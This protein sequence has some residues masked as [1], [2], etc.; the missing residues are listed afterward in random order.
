M[1]NNNNAKDGERNH[2]SLPMIK[3]PKLKIGDEFLKIL[4]DNAFNGID[5]GD[6]TN[7]IK[8]VLEITEWIRILDIDKNE[9]R[10]HVFSKSLSGDAKKWWSNEI[11]GTTI[12][13]NE[14]CNK[15]FHKYYLLSH[16]CNTKVPDDL[17]K[18]TDYFEFLYWLASKFDNYWE[19][20]KNTKNGLWEFYVD[21][22]PAPH[23]ISNPDEL[24]K[25]EEFTVYAGDVVDFRTLLGISLETS[26]MSTIDLDGVT[27]LTGIE[28]RQKDEKR[29]QIG[30]NRAWIWKELKSQK[31]KAKS[32]PREA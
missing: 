2:A 20:D 28:Y 25:T 23:D 9:L 1:S 15:F 3:M 12:I 19:I 31:S 17:D 11:E 8:R 22:F 5:G 13:W 7:H 32:Q 10:L 21:E 4:S 24:C 16:T 27:C 26:M 30:Q 6:V 29:S 14:Q 18:G